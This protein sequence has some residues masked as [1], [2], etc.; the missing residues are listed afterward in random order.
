MKAAGGL[1]CHPVDYARLVALMLNG[2]KEYLPAGKG[3]QLIPADD[4]VAM[5]TPS[6]HKDTGAP[7]GSGGPW[8]GLGTNLSDYTSADGLPTRFDHGGE[9]QGFSIEFYAHREKKAGIVV[10]V[11]GD[12]NG[13]KQREEYGGGHARRRPCC[14]PSRWPTASSARASR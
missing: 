8:Y 1:L 10:M 2:G 6:R 9:H 7:I 5:L 12:R 13:S 3:T 4:V 14:R 11:N